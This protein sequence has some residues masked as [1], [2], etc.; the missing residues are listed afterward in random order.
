MDD[1]PLEERIDQLEARLKDLRKRWPAHTTPPGLMA[2]L[3]ELEEALEQAL[4]QRER[5][6]DAET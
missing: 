5:K 2:E 1:L 6:L 3:D 4:R